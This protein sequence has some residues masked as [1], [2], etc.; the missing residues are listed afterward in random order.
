MTWGA[1]ASIKSLLSIK[2]Q[3]IDGPLAEIKMARCPVVVRGPCRSEHWFEPIEPPSVRI[4]LEVL[5]AA[6]IDGCHGDVGGVR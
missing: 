3:D 6:L 4:A 1:F 2:Q 5:A